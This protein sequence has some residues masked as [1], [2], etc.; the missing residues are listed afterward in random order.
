MGASYLPEVL[1]GA[2]MQITAYGVGLQQTAAVLSVRRKTQKSRASEEM[3][4]CGSG[5]QRQ[6]HRIDKESQKS[7]KDYAP[8]FGQIQSCPYEGKY[9]TWPSE[10]N[11]WQPVSQMEIWKFHNTGGHRS[12]DQPEREGLPEHYQSLAETLERPYLKITAT[13][14]LFQQKLK[15]SFDRNK[16]KLTIRLSIM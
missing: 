10:S 8:A 9:W 2:S 15:P 7:G 16:L 4:I 1:P 13:L 11:Y 14:D 3:V 6:E 5:H 12:Y